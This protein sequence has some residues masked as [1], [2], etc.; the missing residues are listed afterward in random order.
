MFIYLFVILEIVETD[1]Q[2]NTIF[3]KDSTIIFTLSSISKGILGD[4]CNG[5]VLD[6]K[7]KISIRLTLKQHVVN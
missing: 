5:G 4:S 3:R 6:Y 1:F 7:Y 2:L